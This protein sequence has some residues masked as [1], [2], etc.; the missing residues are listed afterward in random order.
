M[1]P[2]LSQE[3]EL[4]FSLLC[5]FPTEESLPTGYALTPRTQV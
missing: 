3:V 5:I 2:I 1:S 4:I